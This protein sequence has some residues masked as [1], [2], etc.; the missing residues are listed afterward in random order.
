MTAFGDQKG[1][2]GPE[3][4]TRKVLKHM[5]KAYPVSSLV[6][7]SLTPPA[8]CFACHMTTATLPSPMGLQQVAV[9]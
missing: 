1:R 3:P 2:Q 4:S 6:I 5:L 7:S 8:C 9:T